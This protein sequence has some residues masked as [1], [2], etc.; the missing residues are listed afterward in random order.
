MAISFS[1]P[2]LP[3]IVCVLF[4]NHVTQRADVFLTAAP[5]AH[6]WIQ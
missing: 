1:V 5:T 6:G 4:R 2:L 3:L